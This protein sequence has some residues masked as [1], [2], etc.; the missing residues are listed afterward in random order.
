VLSVLA[1]ATIATAAA[2]GADHVRR[3]CGL[4]L[5]DWAARAGRARP[6]VACVASDVYGDQDSIVVVFDD[7]PGEPERT[8]GRPERTPG[9]RG[10]RRRSNGNRHAIVALVDH[11][12]YGVLKDIFL[13]VEVDEVLETMG[14]DGE[15]D[16]QP[17]DPGDALARIGRALAVTRNRPDRADLCSEDVAELEWLVAARVANAAT[18]GAR[19]D[20]KGQLSAEHGRPSKADVQAELDRLVASPSFRSLKDDADACDVA[21]KVVDA[22]AR[23]GGLP[24][25]LS[26]LAVLLLL[27]DGLAGQ[28]WTKRHLDKLP[29]VLDAVVAAIVESGQQTA[30]V[31]DEITETLHAAW[32]EAR[33]VLASGRRWAR[34]RRAAMDRLVP[35]PEADGLAWSAEEVAEALA[36]L[37]ALRA[38]VR[39]DRSAAAG[40][41]A[42][43]AASTRKA[44]KRQLEPTLPGL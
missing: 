3:Q 33:K 25:R 36:A 16:A 43:R 27:F 37:E 40:E 38:G 34:D 5:P 4:E 20:G 19:A 17:C 2:A 6:T 31:T 14:S 24:L 39:E 18:T 28:R 9:K 22:L 26:P 35:P 8:E 30:A 32:P 23:D 7:E 13:S 10:A 29:A 42:R 11:N 44:A 1:P 12:L 21:A 41:R 15:L